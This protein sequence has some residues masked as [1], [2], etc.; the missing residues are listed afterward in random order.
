MSKL[1][2]KITIS[3]YQE[4]S[5][6]HGCIISI[7]IKDEKSGCEAIEI[8]MSLYDFANALTGLGYV[9]CKFTFNEAN[10]IGMNREYQKVI[11]S[12]MDI[13]TPS[14]DAIERHMMT[15]PKIAK[16]LIECWRP[17]YDDFRNW[18]NRTDDGYSVLFERW[19]A[20]E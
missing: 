5:T 11:V 14:D 9:D 19:A 4:P 2:G 10:K 6:E 1:N 20:D 3:K 13:I 18:H 16:L 7:S 8:Q 12:E 17:R 15:F